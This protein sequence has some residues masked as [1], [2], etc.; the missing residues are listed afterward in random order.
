[1]RGDEMHIRQSLG[2]VESR[3]EVLGRTLLIVEVGWF[4]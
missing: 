4:G 2:V 3:A 1:M